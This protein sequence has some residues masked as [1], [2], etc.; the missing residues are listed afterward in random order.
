MILVWAV[1]GVVVIAGVG[2]WAWRFQMRAMNLVGFALGRRAGQPGTLVD[3]ELTAV[4][5]DH[6]GSVLIAFRP[7][8]MKVDRRHASHQLPPASNLVLGLLDDEQIALARLTRWR[9]SAAP[10]LLWRDPTGDL[11]ELS[12]LQTGQSVRLPVHTSAI[13]VDTAQSFPGSRT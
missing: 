5:P 13:P 11:V 6:N 9:S 1:F 8:G 7:A 10:L 3:V 4:L 12:Q 2:R